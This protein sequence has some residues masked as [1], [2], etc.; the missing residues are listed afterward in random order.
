MKSLHTPLQKSKATLFTSIVYGLRTV[1]P[2]AENGFAMRLKQWACDSVDSSWI[3][4]WAFTL[5]FSFHVDLITISF[6]FFT[7]DEKQDK[8]VQAIVH[9]HLFSTKLQ[10]RQSG[11]GAHCTVHEQKKDMTSRLRDS[12]ASR[13]CWMAF[14]RRAYGPSHRGPSHNNPICLKLSLA[15]GGTMPGSE[16]S[17]YREP[18]QPITVVPRFT[19]LIRSTGGFSKRIV[20]KANLESP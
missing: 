1:V 9:L 4:L 17:G 8:A 16:T 19:N 3:Q 2:L 18:L 15:K 20:R 10:K 5:P 6:F 12:L 13:T 11:V 7:F 14:D